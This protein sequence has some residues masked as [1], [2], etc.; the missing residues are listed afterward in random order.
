MNPSSSTHGRIQYQGLASIP[1]D[2]TNVP[3]WVAVPA[4]PGFLYCL[5]IDSGGDTYLLAFISGSR[6]WST[7]AEYGT[8]VDS[9][10]NPSFSAIYSANDGNIY[11]TE[12][13]T[14]QIWRFSTADPYTATIM[15][16][17]PVAVGADG[18]RCG[19]NKAAIS[20][21]L[22]AF[23]CDSNGYLMQVSHSTPMKGELGCPALIA[24]ASQTPCPEWISTTEPFLHS[25]LW[26]AAACT[27]P[28]AL[29]R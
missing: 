9:V 15:S 13:N 17:G 1:P 8:T 27:M 4:Q 29:T 2:S 7:V 20:P 12:G 22:P 23:S 6:E 19:S 26:K 18:A 3:D 14:G 28:S 25:L 11:A 24:I 21:A 10:S 5:R 16:Q